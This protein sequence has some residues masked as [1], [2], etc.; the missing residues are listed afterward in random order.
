[1]GDEVDRE[2]RGLSRR[3]ALSTAGKAVIGGMAI[4]AGTGGAAAADEGVDSTSVDAGPAGTSTAEFRGRVL[5]RGS[6]GEVLT[7]FGYLTRLV[8]ASNSALFAGDP[9]N[10]STALFT[11]YAQPT[12]V[13]R[14]LDE[15]VHAVD[16]AGDLDIYQRRAP[17]AHF[18]DPASFKQGAL[19]ARYS[20]QLQDILAVFSPG[21]GIPTLNGDMTQVEAGQL[22]GPLAGKRFGRK[23]QRRR[24]YA[25]GL[26]TLTDPATLNASLELA[27]NWTA[28]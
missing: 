10:E 27:G 3:E 2:S 19:V 4:A 7:T 17:G 28:D 25:T 15:N 5:Q 22:S 9:H 23:N 26:G 24:M 8:G 11:L 16:L 18:D 6:N 1:M 13:A 20:F 14:V 12:L 21:K